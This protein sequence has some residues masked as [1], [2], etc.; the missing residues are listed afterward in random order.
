V[1][2]VRT[3]KDDLKGVARM[4]RDLTR[5]KGDLSAGGSLTAP[6]DTRLEPGAAGRL[7]HFAGVG[8]VSTLSFAVLFALLYGSFGSVG[9]DV[10]ALALCALGNLAANRRFT[11]ADRGRP[12]RRDYYARGLTSA[13]LPVALTLAALATT[14]A[15]GVGR[16]GADLAAITVANLSATAVRYHFLAARSAGLTTRGG[17]R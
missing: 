12:G 2:I 17:R 16:L 9:A 1:D 13:L 15:A 6:P 7:L 14:S 11:F 4:M 5:G 3:A 8:A 10:V